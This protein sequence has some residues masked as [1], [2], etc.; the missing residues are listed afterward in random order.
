MGHAKVTRII[1]TL[2]FDG[3]PSTDKL[4]W[5]Q[6]T[7]RFGIRKFGGSPQ[8]SREQRERLQVLHTICRQSLLGCATGV[9]LQFWH[10]LQARAELLDTKTPGPDSLPTEVLK[11]SHTRL[12]EMAP[13]CE[14]TD[15]DGWLWS[16]GMGNGTT[17][18]HTQGEE[19][20]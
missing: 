5:Q 19:K 20:Y 14:E 17:D 6:E 1:H 7:H 11:R 8:A 15:G 18:W 12:W 10:V 13:V 9:P 2:Q 16:H 3:H 4:K